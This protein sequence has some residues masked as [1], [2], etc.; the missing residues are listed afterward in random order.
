MNNELEEVVAYFGL[1]SLN[2]LE[3]TEENN[4]KNN[5]SL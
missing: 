2:F 4:Q 3:V 5:V 1:L